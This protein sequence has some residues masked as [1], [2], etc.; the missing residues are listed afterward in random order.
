MNCSEKGIFISFF[1][2]A[3]RLIG[4]PGIPLPV[5]PQL[6]CV[7]GIPLTAEGGMGYGYDKNT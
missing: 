2:A 5:I 6:I 4:M 3:P 1:V 7:L